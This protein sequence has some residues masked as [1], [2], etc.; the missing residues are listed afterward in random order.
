MII[1]F[2]LAIAYP[3]SEEKMSQLQTN[4]ESRRSA[5]LALAPT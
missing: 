2:V 1:G 3:L 4:L 5:D